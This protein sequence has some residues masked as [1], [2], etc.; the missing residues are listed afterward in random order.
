MPRDTENPILRLTL[1]IAT[2]GAA[3]R[4]VDLTGAL[5]TADE[6]AAG[7]TYMKTSTA[8]EA[9]A[10]TVLGVATGIAGA[11]IAAGAAL[12]VTAAG[13]LITHTA[14]TVVVAR[15]L[16]AATADGDE[17]AVLVIPN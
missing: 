1:P 12:K 5:P 6:N 14:N 2:A 4:F 16:E 13:K 9:A 8:K 10:V 3:G 7:P 15:A 17:L 11:A